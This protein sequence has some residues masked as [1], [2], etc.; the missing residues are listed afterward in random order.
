MIIGWHDLIFF[1]ILYRVCNLQWVLLGHERCQ[2]SWSS[3]VRPIEWGAKVSSWQGIIEEA[4]SEVTITN[5]SILWLAIG[6]EQLRVEASTI[7]V[8][9]R[10]KVVEVA[11]LLRKS[12]RLVLRVGRLRIGTV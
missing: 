7:L 1:T 10:S 2:P 11:V 12:R 3:D 8:G 9:K 6:I 4:T 5:N